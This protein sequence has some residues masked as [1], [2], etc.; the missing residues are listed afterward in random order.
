MQTENG[1]PVAPIVVRPDDLLDTV[2][3]KLKMHK[4]HRVYIVNEDGEPVGV[5]ALKD[6]LELL[7]RKDDEFKTKKLASQMEAARHPMGIL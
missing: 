7:V 4:I 6:I 2:M 5:V 1:A 3:E